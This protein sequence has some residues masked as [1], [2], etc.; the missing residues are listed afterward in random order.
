MEARRRRENGM[1]SW[2][3]G[4]VIG[5]D[6]SFLEDWDIVY[7]IE[8]HTYRLPQPMQRVDYFH[9]V[10]YGYVVAQMCYQEKDVIAQD[11]ISVCGWLAKR[12]TRIQRRFRTKVRFNFITKLKLMP[13]KIDSQAFTWIIAGYMQ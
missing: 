13:G 6:N 9:G 1:R 4:I 12:M 7:V 2:E 5:R 8:H 3:Q 10:R 11:M